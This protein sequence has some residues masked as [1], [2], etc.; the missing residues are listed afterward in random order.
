[1][2]TVID[3]MLLVCCLENQEGLCREL[4]E[5]R[6]YSIVSLLQLWVERGRDG[7]AWQLN[8]KKNTMQDMVVVFNPFYHTIKSL[9]SVTKCVFNTFNPYDALKHYFVYLKKDLIS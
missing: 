8:L 9:L 6:L 5:L 4:G 7:S 2:D 3:T 1:M